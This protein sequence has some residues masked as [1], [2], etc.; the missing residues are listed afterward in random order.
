MIAIL[1][2]CLLVCLSGL[3]YSRLMKPKPLVSDPEETILHFNIEF[4]PGSEYLDQ[5]EVDLDLDLLEVEPLPPIKSGVDVHDTKVQSSTRLAIARL[6]EALKGTPIRNATEEIAELI[7]GKKDLDLDL[8]LDWKTRELAYN[9]LLVI[10]KV[11]GTISA[12]NGVNAVNAVSATQETE[13]DIL[14]LVWTRINADINK[15]NKTHLAEALIEGLARGAIN[16]NSTHCL[17]GRVTQIIQSLETLDASGIADII[18]IDVLKERLPYTFTNLLQKYFSLFPREKQRYEEGHVNVRR[19]KKFIN[20][21]LRD[22]YVATKL[23][24]EEQ[25]S[26]LLKPYFDNLN[27]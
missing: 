17:T 1:V 3:A 18:T 25:Y 9:T 26:A 6:K 15:G 13:Q 2:L 8:D 22:E 14:N 5:E 16:R 11:N 21:P 4:H 23:L 10:Q 27:V 24:T 19:V 20:E 12:V 7:F